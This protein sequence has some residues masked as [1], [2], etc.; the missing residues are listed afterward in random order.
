MNVYQIW[1]SPSAFDD[2][3]V[4]TATAE[5]CARMREQGLIEADAV[6]VAEFL[7]P[8]REAAAKTHDRYVK[9]RRL[10]RGSRRRPVRF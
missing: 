6:L 7:A 2:R 5:T 3:S 4:T 1:D 10:A 8:S 9:G